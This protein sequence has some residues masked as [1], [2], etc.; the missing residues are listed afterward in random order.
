MQIQGK[1]GR[2]GYDGENGSDANVTRGNIAKALYENSSD[3]YDDGIYSYR[4]GGQYYLAINASYI[5][6]GNID[7]DLI[8]LTCGYG[9]F[10]KGAVQM[11][12]A[13]EHMAL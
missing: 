8:E 6:A 1:D 5:L 12:A 10:A 7:A 13:D 11:A 9:G 2:D 4:Y 3:Y